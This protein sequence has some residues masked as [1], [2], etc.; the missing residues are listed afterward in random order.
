MARPV[1]IWGILC[2]LAGGCFR[3][4]EPAEVSSP[5]TRDPNAALASFAM[6]QIGVT[7][8]YDPAYT[9]MKYPGGDVP[10][11]RGVCTDVVI[12]ALR[13]Q[14][15]DLQKLIHEDM[16][17]HFAEYPSKWGLSRPDPNIDHRR[18]ENI[19]CY[20]TRAKKAVPITMNPDHYR[21]GD[22]VTWQLKSGRA[23]IGI[24]SEQRSHQGRPLIIHNIGSGTILE[25]FLFEAKVTGHFRFWPQA[26]PIKK[27]A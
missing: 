22:I 5:P 10:L 25:D 8:Q 1:V 14:D 18:V 11:D 13:H 6:R 4:V 19:Q 3:P 15:V 26:A 12:R 7:R 17:K 23:H 20:L 2:A 27:R 16:A 24:V 21:P 9:A